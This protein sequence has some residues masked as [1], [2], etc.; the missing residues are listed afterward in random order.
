MTV[1]IRELGLYPV[2]GCRGLQPRSALLAPTGLASDA[3]GAGAIG[4]RE[5]VI[6]DQNGRFVSQ[7]EHPRMALIETTLTATHLRMKAPGMLLLEVPFASEGNVL[8]VQV[9][10]DRVAAVTQ[11]E[12]ADAWVS[13]FLGLPARLMRFDAEARRHSNLT[14]TAPLV[15][16]YK[17]ADAFAVLVTNQASLEDLNRRLGSTGAAPATMARFRPNLVLE[18]LPA[19]EEDYIKMLHIGPV[20][21]RVVKRCARCTVPGVDPVT[22]VASTAV[23]DALAT[24]RRTNDGVMFGV[25]AIVVEGAGN[26]L[27]AGTP[28]EIEL[29]LP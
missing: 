29:D 11:G 7:R 27:R 28:V 26:S 21:L 24:Y 3:D 15:A 1:R 6:V 4:D 10:N 23:P 9:W 18:G 13:S 25:N 17:F 14:Y 5:W 16:P 22:G 2:K 19:Y 12:V 20:T 8:E